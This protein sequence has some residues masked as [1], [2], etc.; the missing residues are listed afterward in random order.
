MI[1]N[2]VDVDSLK[3]Y[4]NSSKSKENLNDFSQKIK[5]LYFNNGELPDIETVKIL[6]FFDESV[7]PLIDDFWNQVSN[8]FLQE[9][10]NLS[11]D[12]NEKY[13][14]NIFILI[15]EFFTKGYKTSISNF[16]QRTLILDTRNA[17]KKNEWVRSFE[18]FLLHV[19]PP[20]EI[21]SEAIK[22]I[23]KKGYFFSLA[24]NAQR[25]VFYWWLHV[26]W[27]HKP[28]INHPKWKEFHLPLKELSDEALKQN[29]FAT[30][31][32]IHFFAYQ[33]LGNLYQTSVEWKEL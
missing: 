22:G 28:Y 10:N 5:E 25:S 18:Y 27:T 8:Y 4:L 6:R 9:F 19:N 3:N 1:I 24:R 26:V 16:F 17:D 31:M 21:V 20:I 30:Q 33:I 29:D 11:D 32:Y 12:K 2:C 15:G 13:I 23:I 14:Y 7:E